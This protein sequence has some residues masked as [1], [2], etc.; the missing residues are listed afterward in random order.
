M[1][2]YIALIALLLLASPVGASEP[3]E[4]LV[5]DLTL[6]AEE[7]ARHKAE[8]DSALAAYDEKLAD[9]FRRFLKAIPHREGA[10]HAA[11]RAL[12]RSEEQHAVTVARNKLAGSRERFEQMLGFYEHR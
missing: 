10:M 3:E 11:L 9:T 6:V 12:E 1:H 2:K 4:L 5:V 7:A 8:L